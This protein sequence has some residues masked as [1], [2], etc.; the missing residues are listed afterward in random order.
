MKPQPKKSGYTPIPGSGLVPRDPALADIEDEDRAKLTAREVGGLSLGRV[1][2]RGAT[3]PVVLD[4][5]DRLALD[6]E[7]EELA[8]YLHLYR[9]AVGDER[10]FCRVSRAELERR[11]RM[12]QLRLGKALA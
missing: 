10:N 6:Q 4:V 1:V 8:V 7:P 3:L 2:V 5:F 11:V 9:L 12:S